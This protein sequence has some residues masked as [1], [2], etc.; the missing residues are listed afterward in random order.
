ME[1]EAVFED[2]AIEKQSKE[3]FNPKDFIVRYSSKSKLAKRQAHGAE[4]N[5]PTA[6]NKT[7]SNAKPYEDVSKKPK[8]SSPSIAYQSMTDKQFPE[9]MRARMKESAQRVR[10]AYEAALAAGVSK[11]ELLRNNPGLERTLREAETCEIIEDSSRDDYSKTT[12]TCNGEGCSAVRR[13][14]AKYCHR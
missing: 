5:L 4:Q 14:N 11:E 12:E 13:E 10:E 6:Q 3:A 1:E 7:N 2:G 8:I 9:F